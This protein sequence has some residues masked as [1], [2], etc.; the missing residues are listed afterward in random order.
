MKVHTLRSRAALTRGALCAAVLAAAFAMPARAEA[1]HT[2]RVV[3]IGGAVSEILYDLGL[4]SQVVGV[5]T[6]SLYP[7]RALHEKAN[8]GYMR[9]LSAEGVLSLEPSLVLAVEGSGPPDALKQISDAKVALTIVPDD[10]TAEG[11]A[12]K[13]TAVGKLTGKDEA[14]RQ[15]A[16]SVN[17]RFA[18]LAADRAR[19]QKPA[20]VLFVLSLQNGRAMAAGRHT[21]ADSIIGL[22][23][24]V[25]AVAEM[26]GYKPLT[27]EAVIAAAPDIVLMMVR[28]DGAA[29]QDVFA[30]PAF[31]AT[32]AAAKKAL[33][34]MDGLYLLGFGPRTPDAARELMA[35]LYPGLAPQPAGK[36]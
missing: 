30:L 6:T 14:A 26:D 4:E 3:A 36:P 7:A 11:V 32:P 22:A 19:I 16:E 20:R 2:G 35:R 31:S 21:A 23:G 28:G 25:N 8:V 33:V 1:P 10:Q 13:I 9:A 27:D 34:V 12:A 5:D 17:A 18:A 15:L 29:P 24:G